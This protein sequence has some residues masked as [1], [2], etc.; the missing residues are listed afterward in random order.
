MAEVRKC[1][2][3]GHSMAGRRKDARYCGTVC[4]VNAS[5]SR[6]VASAEHA[7][8]TPSATDAP[9]YTACGMD[10]AWHARAVQLITRYGMADA[11]TRV[12]SGSLRCTHGVPVGRRCYQ[13]RPV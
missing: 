5:R 13:C 2:Q 7:P 12:V 1:E 3:C 9:V 6:A 4:R 8:V 10:E 11:T